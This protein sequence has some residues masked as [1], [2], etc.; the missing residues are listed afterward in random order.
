MLYEHAYAAP[1]DIF[2]GTAHVIRHHSHM[3]HFHLLAPALL[4]LLVACSPSSES[5]DT[6]DDTSSAR[7]GYGLADDLPAGSFGGESE[8]NFSGDVY[9]RG[10]TETTTVDEPFCEQNCQTFEYVMFHVLESGSESLANFLGN[11]EGN[12]YA[13]RARIGLGCEEADGTIRYSNHSDAKQMQEFHL[14]LEDTRA[15]LNATEE[16]PVT[17]HLTKELLTGGSEAPACYSHFTT[18][19]VSSL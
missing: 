6:H 13:G 2:V 19:E 4:A 5:P 18:I 3:K 15:I 11:N 8:G 7:L 10:Y 17:L 16:N 14:S 1:P 9:V 12:A